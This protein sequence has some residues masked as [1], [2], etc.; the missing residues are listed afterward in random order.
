M[1]KVLF[2]ATVDIHIKTFHLPYLKYFKEKGYEVHVATNTGDLID[3]CDVKH[4]ICISR[5]PFKICNLKAIRE[6]KK[7]I[8]NEKFDI[9][10]CHT[11]MGSVVARISAK[12]ARKKYN[13]RV[14]YTAHGFHFYKGA[15]LLNWLLFY[16]VEKYLSKF[17]DDIITI[18]KDDYN[19]ALK[20][21]KS[22]IHYV[23]GVGIDI[24][25]FDIKMNDKQ[26][27]M[28]KKEFGL[29][30]NDYVLTCVARLD[31]NKNQGFL[32]DIMQKVVKKYNNIHLLLVGRDEI[33]G[34]YQRLVKEKKIDGNVHFLG[35]RDDIP[36]I[37]SITDI[38]LSASK[39]EGLPVN[40]L[41]AFAS[42]TP[43]VALSCRGM[44]DLIDNGI[45]G[46]VIDSNNREE[47]INRILRI[48]ENPKLTE[49]ISRNNREKIKNY[50]LNNIIN[51]YKKI[52][53]CE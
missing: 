51:E 13:T 27:I 40:V 34:F 33:N 16:P 20:K 21:F 49:I 1:K 37:L 5:S 45:N 2:V 36:K 17:T 19:F 26:E 11:P 7:I 8:N 9:I 10:H 28:Y 4:K 32:I 22:R 38:V 42:G 39:R 52:Y 41:E 18:N 3:Y 24:K 12:R 50:D 30:E 44:Y 48:Y 14:I 23:A 29:K 47:Y 31:T 35:N 43:V 6:L 53:E 15:P 25:R 46:Y